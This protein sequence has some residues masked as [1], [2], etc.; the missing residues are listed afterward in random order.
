M[1]GTLSLSLSLSPTILFPFLF[2]SFCH[3][4][5]LRGDAPFWHPCQMS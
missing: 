3:R 5:Q 1:L 4:M 2:L